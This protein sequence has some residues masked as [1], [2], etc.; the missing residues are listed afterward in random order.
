[1]AE[2][3]QIAEIVIIHRSGDTFSMPV[4][5]ISTREHGLSPCCSECPNNPENGGDELCVCTR[6]KKILIM[7]GRKRE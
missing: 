2:E 3:D 6:G 7:K 5:D 1:M 4:K